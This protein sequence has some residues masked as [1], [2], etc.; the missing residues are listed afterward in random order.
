MIR[1]SALVAAA[2]GLLSLF[3]H[4]LGINFFGPNLTENRSDDGPINAVE[5]GN[6]F[7]NFTEITPDPVQP[8]PAVTPEPPIEEVITP[9]RAEIPISETHVASPDPKQV[10]SPDVGAPASPQ[11]EVQEEVLTEPVAPSSTETTANSDAAVTPPVTQEPER[12]AA[13]P[14]ANDPAAPVIPSENAEVDPEIPSAIDE[15]ETDTS[16]QA[17]TVSKRPRLPDRRPAPE[18]QSGLSGFKN[19]DKLRFP[20][21]TLESP[22]SRYQKEGTDPFTANRNQSTGRGTG[23]SNTTNYAGQVLVHLNRAP[24]VYVPVRGFAQ[25]F[26]EINPDGSLA[27]IDIVDSSGSPEIERAAKEQVMRAAPFPRPPSGSSR[28]LSFYYQNN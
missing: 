4:F 24:V 6:S 3:L 7:E 9:E 23:N 8:E 25:V 16:E 10:T 5:L 20:E 15:P 22:L 2:A 14:P 26:F 28:R 18:T 13:L 27:W 12:L 21:T 1:K 17:V 19:F 11:S